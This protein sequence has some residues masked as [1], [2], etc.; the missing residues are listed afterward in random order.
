MVRKHLILVRPFGLPFTSFLCFH[1]IINKSIVT[2]MTSP[3]KKIVHEYINNFKV[4]P[5]IIDVQHLKFL[6]LIIKHSQNII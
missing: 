4:V 5:P 6:I 3:K 1:V 2:H